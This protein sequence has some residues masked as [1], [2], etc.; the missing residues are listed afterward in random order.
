MDN[1]FTETIAAG[2]FLKNPEETLKKA[3]TRSIGI[4]RDSCEPVVLVPA[5][6]YAS[7]RTLVGRAIR[8]G[9]MADIIKHLTA[10]KPGPHPNSPERY[11]DEQA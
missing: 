10:A 3:A 7:M 2:A 8:S 5:H 4:T 11:D 9:A 1:P 6:E